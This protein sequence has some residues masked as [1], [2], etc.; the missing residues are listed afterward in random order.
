M[1][2]S[3]CLG[4]LFSFRC[5][6]GHFC[7]LLGQEWKNIPT[8]QYPVVSPR[9]PVT[10]LLPFRNEAKHMVDLLPHL[11]SSASCGCPS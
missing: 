4:I 5:L 2:L 6:P 8:G 10:V 7:L 1:V 9:L 3:D 11:T